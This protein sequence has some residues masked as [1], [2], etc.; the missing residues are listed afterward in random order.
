MKKLS[1]LICLILTL[2]VPAEVWSAGKLYRWKDENGQ[3]QISDHV[4]PEQAVHERSEL[5]E[6]GRTVKIHEAA[7]TQEQIEQETLLKQLQK[8]KAELLAELQKSDAV[9]LKTFQKEED[10]DNTLAAKLKTLDS[11][12]KLASDQ[13]AQQQHQLLAQQKKAAAYERD[14]KA[15]P[16]K[17]LNDLNNT[18]QVIADYETEIKG[19]SEQKIELKQQTDKDK[20]RFTLLKQHSS[21]GLK[22]NEAGI[23]SLDVGHLQCATPSDCDQLWAKALGYSKNVANTR[24]LMESDSLL[25]TTHATTGD[26]RSVSLSRVD[27]EG[28]TSIYLDIRCKDSELGRANCKGE[29]T[30]QIIENF[31]GL[32]AEKAADKTN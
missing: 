21:Q 9:L 28:Q 19:I 20:S 23:P 5:N 8:Q 27:T 22:I 6:D 29:Q 13:L 10:I 25:L 31:N 26:D 11:R 3:W 1:L 12:H 7:K 14:G 18:Q 4:P 16:E 15:I 2:P 24:L 32:T 30:K 17:V